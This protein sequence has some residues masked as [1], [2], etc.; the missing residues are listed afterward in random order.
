MSAVSS[1]GSLAMQIYKEEGRKEIF[2]KYSKQL[3]S[4]WQKVSD[5][6]T[7]AVHTSFYYL[8]PSLRRNW[9]SWVPDILGQNYFLGTTN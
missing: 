8:P 1:A 6:A 9:Y 4:G 5:T 3:Q 7:Y 2:V